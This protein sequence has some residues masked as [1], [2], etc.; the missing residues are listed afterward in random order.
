MIDGIRMSQADLRCAS[1]TVPRAWQR[2]LEAGFFLLP[3][4]CWAGL[5]RPFSTPKIWLLLGLDVAVALIYLLPARR[6]S[7]VSGTPAWP[8]LLW[9]AAVGLSCL[10]APRVSL[11]A[12]LLVL[13][14]L[15]LCWAA[16]QGLFETTRIERAILAGTLVECAIVVL[17]YLWLD[18][19]RWLGW[20]PELFPGSRM[21]VYGTMGNPD[22]AAA[23]LCATLPL[24]FGMPRARRT[25]MRVAAI[26][27]H[28]A[29]ILATGSRV[30]LLALP[31]A[32]VVLAV[33][34]FRIPK[35]CWLAL[36]VAVAL[37]YSSRSRPL[38]L[39]VQGRLFPVR[40]MAGHLLR[41]P[42]AGFGPGSFQ[43]QFALWQAEWFRGA[44]HPQ[45]AR[46]AA[47]WDHAHNDYL[48]LWTEYGP[49]G[50][51]AFLALCGF[52]ML[53]ARRRLAAGRAARAAVWSAAACLLA[54]ACVDFPLHR[55][56]E[57]GLL[58]LLLGMLGSVVPAPLPAREIEW[59]AAHATQGRDVFQHDCTVQTSR[60]RRIQ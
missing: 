8:F 41:I 44:A 48:E 53:R 29:A 58:W 2:P 24:W 47:P 16:Y 4:V 56:A 32:A 55:P 3:L 21:R 33:L 1:C 12:L 35:W 5:D 57:S 6:L 13:L 15:P 36:P 18:P 11:D 23:W 42:P 60:T 28:L 27:L 37:L 50:I 14:P 52:L 10:I 46:F 17:Q 45:D 59:A 9:L 30:F 26:G 40:V 34:R 43:V 19:L 54:I 22:F 49:L 38:G 31:A 25:W 39:T 51:G 7:R 20:Q